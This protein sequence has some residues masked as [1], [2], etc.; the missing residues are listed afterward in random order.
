[1][2]K[3]KNEVGLASVELIE[4][5]LDRGFLIGDVIMALMEGLA[6]VIANLPVEYHA[7]TIENC[8]ASIESIVPQLARQIA[9]ARSA[10]KPFPEMATVQ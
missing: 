3:S 10:A 8:R 6:R 7:E 9:A 4:E 1:M 5:L 2:S